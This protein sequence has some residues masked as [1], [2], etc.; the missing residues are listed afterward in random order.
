MLEISNNGIISINRGDY[1]EFPL[2]INQGNKMY[3]IRYSLIRDR[4][5]NS[6]VLF[7]VRSYN[8]TLQNASIRKTYNLNSPHSDQRDLIIVLKP[9]DTINLMPGK[10]FYSITL[11]LFQHGHYCQKTII[12]EKL[13]FIKE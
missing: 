7:T 4:K 10:Y 6:N 9:E 3:P 5:N 1:A 2:F 11:N 8:Q 12:P 13:F